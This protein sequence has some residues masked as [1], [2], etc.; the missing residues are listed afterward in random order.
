MHILLLTELFLN[1]SIIQVGD[2]VSDWSGEQT[3]REV[4]EQP[5]AVITSQ[6]SPHFL[7]LVLTVTR[8]SEP[9]EHPTSTHNPFTC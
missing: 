7:P 8:A 9:D 4:R 5:S 1:I 2:R 3:D 6:S